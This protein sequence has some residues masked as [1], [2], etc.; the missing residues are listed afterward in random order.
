MIH[1]LDVFIH[2]HFSGLMNKGNP[3]Q[4]TFLTFPILVKEFQYYII[5]YLDDSDLVGKFF[6][7]SPL[8][9]KT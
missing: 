6:L 8:N 4:Q 9:Y 7:M 5:H 1:P 2:T 3:T